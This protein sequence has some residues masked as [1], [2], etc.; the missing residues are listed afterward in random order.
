MEYPG[1]QLILFTPDTEKL[2]CVPNKE[3]KNFT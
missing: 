2:V 1:I 3:M